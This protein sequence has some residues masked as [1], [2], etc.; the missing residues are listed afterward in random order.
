VIALLKFLMGRFLFNWSVFRKVMGKS[1]WF[2]AQFNL[3]LNNP[4]EFEYVL[5]S[6]LKN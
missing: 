2:L 5:A 3:T 6:S 1:I 4:V